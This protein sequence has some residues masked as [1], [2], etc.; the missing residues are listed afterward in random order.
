MQ[1]Y[2]TVKLSVDGWHSRADL[3]SDYP[4]ISSSS[5]AIAFICCSRALMK[6]DWFHAL[7]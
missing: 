1:P 7:I 3:N 2:V 6:L 5:I 4:K